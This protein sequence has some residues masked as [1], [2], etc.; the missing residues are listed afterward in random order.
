MSGKIFISYRREDSR[1]A[2]GRI[3]DRLETHFGHDKLFMDVDT[4]QPGV[5]F[6]NA[7]EEAVKTTDIFLIV[8]GPDWLGIT[9]NTGN[10]RIDNPEDFVRLEV[11]SALRRNVRVIPVL[12][13][14]A[15]MPR[16]IDLPEDL[17]P[18]T[19]RNAI[20]ISH[21][22]FSMD[23]ERL[24][25]SIELAFNQ[26]G[27]Q[28]TAKE[29]KVAKKS[30]QTPQLTKR[31][32]SLFTKSKKKEQVYKTS[33]YSIWSTVIA[34]AIGGAMG[35]IVGDI[36]YILYH[37]SHS[38]VGLTFHYVWDI[39]LRDQFMVTWSY[40]LFYGALA[41]I[42]LIVVFH[43]KLRT[44]MLVQFLLGVSYIISLMVIDLIP[45]INSPLIYQPTVYVFYIFY[46]IFVSGVI[47][48]IRTLKGRRS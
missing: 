32:A 25:R 27:V 42:L 15:T 36:F 18:L 6:V 14:K 20:E 35:I 30:K 45:G 9:D 40:G 28:E 3:Y 43:K 41:G 10:R 29:N 33:A 44:T 23:A 24:I 39:L 48:W 16:S 1:G 31:L 38:R 7:I 13:D 8:I 17:Q 37:S 12:V 11:S 22:R 19:R 21:T 2:A 26:I 5:D 47:H 4:I 34:C 46:V